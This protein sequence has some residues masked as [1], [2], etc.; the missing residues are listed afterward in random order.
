MPSRFVVLVLTF[1]LAAPL[2]A[3]TATAGDTAAVQSA[4]SVFREVES[5]Q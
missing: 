2:P 5:A 3:Q 4:Q 1:A